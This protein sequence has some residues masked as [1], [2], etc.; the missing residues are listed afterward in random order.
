MYVCESKKKQINVRESDWYSLQRVE[1]GESGLTT[2]LC[3]LLFLAGWTGLHCED[4]INECLPQPCNQGI[5]I[6]N[7]PG[8]G[9]TCFCRPGFVVRIPTLSPPYPAFFF[10]SLTSL[11]L[12]LPR[13]L[14][15][16]S[17]LINWT[18]KM[19]DQLLFCCLKP[20]R[21]CSLFLRIGTLFWCFSTFVWQID[22]K[23][24]LRKYDTVQS[25]CR[26]FS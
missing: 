9:Y 23:I 1:V 24:R 6:Q 7:D 14:N 2:A 12:L 13:P 11:A 18:V 26:V 20:N 4:D 25:F 3:G 19:H 22:T 10:S 17:V 16:S 5:C 8:Y 15:N 21:F